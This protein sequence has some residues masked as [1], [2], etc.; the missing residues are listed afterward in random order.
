MST[1]KM[2]TTPF[3]GDC[4]AAKRY[5][6]ERGIA[7]EEIN[8]EEVPGAAE[9]VIKANDGKRKVPTFDVDGRFFHCSP[10]SR[11]RLNEALGIG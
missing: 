3:C 8:I 4:R 9:V 1:I 5:L 10:F 11:T 7:F 2:Y 6:T